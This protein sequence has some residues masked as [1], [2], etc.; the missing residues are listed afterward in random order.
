[1]ARL[2]STVSRLLALGGLTA[3][4]SSSYAFYRY[5]LLGDTTPSAVECKR[6]SPVNYGSKDEPLNT[7]RKSWD[8]DW[9][10][11]KPNIN[12]YKVD[13]D[14]VVPVLD[15]DI[16]EKP[17]IPKPTATR[18]VLLI[19][20]G[21]YNMDSKE[22][23]F[24]VLTEIGRQQAEATTERLKSMNQKFD[25]LIIST[26]TRAQETGS[27]ISEGLPDIPTTDYCSLLREGAPYPPEP[28]SKNWRPDNVQFF[29]DNPRIEAAFRKYI[30]RADPSQTEDSYDLI[31]CHSNV[32]RYFVCRAL[33]FP[34]E[35]W[36]R[37]S[38]GNCGLTWLT[39]RPSGNVSLRGMGDIGHIPPDLTTF[40]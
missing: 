15:N 37:M 17:I 26:M 8:D 33:Q 10:F 36:L 29:K 40:N 21:Q 27:I 25:R 2:R 23:K 38:I 20:H 28:K 5:S 12:N 13:K 16:I 3:A 7:D 34:P 35:G 11:R 24:R 4:T 30:H 39:I 19:R 9:D 14:V 22:D 18:H 1:M 32:I 31:V 6:A